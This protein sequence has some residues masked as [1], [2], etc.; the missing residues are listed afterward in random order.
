MNQ[1]KLTLRQRARVM[2]KIIVKKSVKGNGNGAANNAERLA[3]KAEYKAARN[4]PTGTT[5]GNFT[6]PPTR[7]GQTPAQH[8]E[9]P[10]ESA[11]AM[12][13][14]RTA[15]SATQLWHGRSSSMRIQFIDEAIQSAGEHGRTFAEI[16]LFVNEKI[17]AKM[18]GL[19]GDDN[20][21][22]VKPQ[23]MYGHVWAR[24]NRDHVIDADYFEKTGRYR[25]IIVGKG[26]TARI[27]SQDEIAQEIADKHR[28]EMAKRAA[29]EAKAKKK[30]KK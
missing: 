24:M 19:I 5:A 20:Q 3:A 26:K 14:E 12:A 8:I 10:R 18:G 29:D 11:A 2:G 27:K 23:G 6:A 13:A 28:A 7:K 16:V 22:Y 30:A 21:P 25:P 15:R 4:A 1:D 9:S 17:I